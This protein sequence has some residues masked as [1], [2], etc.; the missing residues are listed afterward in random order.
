MQAIHPHLIYGLERNAHQALAL[1]R[2]MGEVSR[3]DA[4]QM[5]SL[6]AVDQGDGSRL[7]ERLVPLC[8]KLYLLEVVPA[9]RLPA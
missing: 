9:N 3:Q 8:L 5:R 6:M 1:L 2:R 4:R 7:P